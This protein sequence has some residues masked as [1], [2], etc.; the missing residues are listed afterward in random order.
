[1]QPCGLGRN[2]RRL[3]NNVLASVPVSKL[4][5]SKR[6]FSSYVW[7]RIRAR[8]IP[9]YWHSAHDILIALN[10][11]S[12]RQFE[13]RSSL[14][15]TSRIL[16]NMLQAECAAW[17]K[18]IES[19]IAQAYWSFVRLNDDGANRGTD[20]LLKQAWDERHLCTRHQALRV[21]E[22]CDRPIS[23]GRVGELTRL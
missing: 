9:S 16:I 7:R 10:F 3:A 2:H 6:R 4:A 23:N 18:T 14:T 21:R 17:L 13:E 11:D 8:R 22:V 1:V 12:D 15:M 5:P 20:H 19:A